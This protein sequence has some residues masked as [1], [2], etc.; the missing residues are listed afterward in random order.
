MKI[1]DL[2]KMGSDKYI[3]LDAGEVWDLEISLDGLRAVYIKPIE[4]DFQIGAK[5][6][7][8]G[9]IK[10]EI[11]RLENQ[12]PEIEIIEREK[13]DIINGQIKILERL[14]DKLEWNKKE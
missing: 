5:Q 7:V 1:K 11:S 8:N 13:F 9:L 6:Y 3:L 4:K 2:E 10:M 12:I 14:Y